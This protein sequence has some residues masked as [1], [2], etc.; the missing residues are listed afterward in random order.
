MVH[1][2]RSVVMSASCQKRTHA[3]QQNVPL[4]DHLVGAGAQLRW[5]GEAER[6]GHL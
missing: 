2:E 6:F 4:F 1:R 3:P 5:H